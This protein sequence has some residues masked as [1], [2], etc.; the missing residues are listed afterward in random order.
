MKI[1]VTSKTKN[2]SYS[3]KYKKEFINIADNALALL[4]IEDKY[5]ISVIF[6]NSKQIKRINAQY[7]NIDKSTDVISFALLDSEDDYPLIYDDEIELGD[8]FINIEA[9]KNQAEEY[10]HSFKREMCFLFTHGLLHCLGYDHMNKK[11]EKV[12]FKLQD[13]ILNPLVPRGSLDE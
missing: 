11:D 5:S 7:R 13:D 3:R 6:V 8:I 2:D 10:R 9:C 4:N 12:M 1:S